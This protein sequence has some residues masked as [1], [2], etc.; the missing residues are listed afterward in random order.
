[1]SIPLHTTRLVERTLGRYCQRICPPTARNAVQLGF[2]IDADRVTLYE[3]RLLCGVPGTHRHVSVAQLRYSARSGEWR[4]FHADQP[5]GWKRHA[6]QAPSR[7][8][9]EL[10]RAIDAD[11]AGLFW[12]R[13][14]GKSLRWC[15]PRGRCEGCEQRYCAMLGGEQR[16]LAPV[17]AVGSAARFRRT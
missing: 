12:G 5:W 8:F 10:L 17:V 14:N 13:V 7:S 1:M 15:S 2:R 3:I 9:I 6:A 16:G 11:E 4:L